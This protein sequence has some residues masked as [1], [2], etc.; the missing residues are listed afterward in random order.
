[1]IASIA[2][3]RT[4]AV[5]CAVTLVA[6]LA[7]YSGRSF[8]VS[9]SHETPALV[10]LAAVRFPNLTR[11][12]RAMLEYADRSN[13]VRG[14]FAV[15]GT[16]NNQDDPSNDP[17]NADKWP[18]DRDIRAGL[19]RWL[20]VEPAAASQVDPSGVRVMGA[21]IIDSLNLAGVRQ[22]FG[23][24]VRKSKI[25]EP[26]DLSGA[27]LRFLG[28]GGSRTREVFA[29]GIKLT[30]GVIR[31][32]ISDGG[33]GPH[34]LRAFASRVFRANTVQSCRSRFTHPL[35]VKSPHRQPSPLPC[36]SFQRGGRAPCAPARLDRTG[37]N[38]D[39]NRR[40]RFGSDADSG[41]TDR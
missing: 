11:A 15:A 22:S 35:G 39:R 26:I 29:P 2:C 16:S 10:E 38:G 8:A 33:Q 32:I 31:K 5:V 9:P 21:N 14:Q 37:M 19:I 6:L 27:D 4:P 12:E 41:S 23:L 40:F 7:I 18:H 17:G 1:M 3:R 34:M 28:L 25:R 13:L 30:E 20:F 36:R 24:M